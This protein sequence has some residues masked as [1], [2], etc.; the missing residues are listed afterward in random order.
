MSVCPDYFRGILE[1]NNGDERKFPENAK[2]RA[3][4]ITQGV[5]AILH[6]Y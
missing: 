4:R 3:K 1:T 5:A 2:E 6:E